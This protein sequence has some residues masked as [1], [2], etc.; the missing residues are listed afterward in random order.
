MHIFCIFLQYLISEKMEKTKL[1]QARTIKGFTQQQ[2]AKALHMD[3]SN[4]NRR[5]KGSIKIRCEEWQKI[6]NL[7]KINIE[8]IYEQEDKMILV[9]KNPTT[10]NCLGNNHIYAIPE[11]FLE[12]QKKYIE[13]LEEENKTL[14]EKLSNKK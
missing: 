9:S 2:I 3:V 7:L 1:I 8:D 4:Y 6:S 13:K 11:Y 12:Y 5:E 10:S 14:K